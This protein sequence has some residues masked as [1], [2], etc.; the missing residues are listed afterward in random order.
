M[1]PKVSLFNSQTRKRQTTAL[2]V[3]LLFAFMHVEVRAQEQGTQNNSNIV[4]QRNVPRPSQLVYEA[5]IQNFFET[6]EVWRFKDR[7][8]F[9]ALL[10]SL[11]L[12]RD[13][14]KKLKGL[15][16]DRLSADESLKASVHY[17]L[18]GTSGYVLVPRE[19]RNQVPGDL[20]KEVYS[21]QFKNYGIKP[22][23][24]F[25]LG[26]NQQVEQFFKTQGFSE[27]AKAAVLKNTVFL[28]GK[29]LITVTPHTWNE[30]PERLRRAFVDGN[31]IHSPINEGIKAH[32][33]L[34]Q[35][36]DITSIAKKYAGERDYRP[37][38]RYLRRALGTSASVEVPLEKIMHPFIRQ[39]IDHYT[40]CHGPNCFNSG[41]NVNR[42]HSFRL[43]HVPGEAPLMKEVYSK[44]RFVTPSEQLQAGDLLLY[45]DTKG[46]V[47]HV[48]SFVGDGIVFTKNGF[49]KFTPYI[50][51]EI[52]TNE[53]IYF[54]DGKY[55]LVALRIPKPGETP[56]SPHSSLFGQ[57]TFYR[58][59]PELEYRA[60][61]FNLTANQIERAG[62]LRELSRGWI[63]SSQMED[64]TRLRDDPR[65]AD[66]QA[67]IQSVISKHLELEKVRNHLKHIDFYPFGDLDQNK[68]ALQNLLSNQGNLDLES[69]QAL[70]W[71]YDYHSSEYGDALS[72]LDEKYKIGF[73]AS[74]TNVMRCLTQ[75]LN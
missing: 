49:N 1:M 74:R 50:F 27:S 68:R 54:P 60:I 18:G 56:V 66:L 10:D 12:S 70:K 20:V 39:M 58:Q 30:F 47:I 52:G 53:K 14:K 43:E 48:S 29:Y 4:T 34:R 11:K 72:R 13:L 21:Y 63:S 22:P 41:L 17:K 40:E 19:I 15:Y 45:R 51:Q 23:I 59:H 32:I 71:I 33:V 5:W 55:Q 67:D 9:E 3:A 69:R 57:E 64:L 73:E 31:L 62:R 16:K 36:D 25:E 37:I 38:E 7:E 26:D 8:E 28:D 35:G 61:G 42:G 46:E 65:A 6:D 44:Y 24:R 75:Q 2:I